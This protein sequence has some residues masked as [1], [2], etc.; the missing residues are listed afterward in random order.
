MRGSQF[1]SDRP[2]AW[3]PLLLLALT[4]AAPLLTG[5]VVSAPAE[6]P[7]PP[8]KLR[9]GDAAAPIRY[10][11]DLTVVP[12]ND[13]FAGTIEIDLQLRQPTS[14]LWVNGSDLTVREA[15][16][17]VRGQSLPARPVPG[18]E[19]FLGFAFDRPVGPGPALLK[20]AYQGKMSEREQAGLFRRKDGEHWYVF[21][22]FEPL[23]ARRA[24][25][26]FDE[27]AYKVPWQLTLHVKRE[28]IALSNT[29]ILAETDEPE[30][31]KAVRFA[32]T[33]PLPSYLVALTVGPF[34]VVDAGRVG[35]KRTPIRIITPRGRAGEAGYAA[36]TTGEILTRL[37]NYFGRPY[38]YEKLDQVAIPQVGFAMENAGLVTYSQTGIL[39]RPQDQTLRFQRGFAGVCAHELAHQWF[40]DLVT[41][42]WWDDLWLNEAFATWMDPKIVDQWKPEW[43]EK[44]SSVRR[45]HWAMESDS[46]VTARRIRQPIESR[47]DIQNA[48]DGIT[49]SKGAAVLDMFETWVGE[50]TFRNGVRR[51]MARHAWGNATAEDFIRA[52]SE[53]AGRDLMPA[54]STFL[55]Q[56]GV[57]LVT[58]ELKCDNGARP[59]LVLA[60]ERYLP[61]G[62][63]GSARQTWQI[64]LRIRYGGPTEGREQTLLTEATVELPLGAAT[65]CPRWVLANEDQAGYYRVLYQGDLLS[66]LLTERGARLTLAERAGLVSDLGAFVRSGRMAAGEVLARVPD[67]L[68]ESDRHIVSG[69]VDIVLGM[70]NLI[71]DELR[72]HYARYI[73]KIYGPR[74]RALGWRPRKGEDDETR[75]LRPQLLGLV[76]GEG[77]DPVLIAEA[78]RLARRWLDDRRSL[79]GDLVGPILRIAARNGDRAL[80]DR[81]HAEARKTTDLRQRNDLLWAMSAFR[82]AEILKAAFAIP[83]TDE[84]HPTEAMGLIWGPSGDPKTRP[85]AYEFVKTNFDAL[86]AKL[87]RDEGAYLPYIAGGFC[88]EERRAEV[89]AFFKDRSTKF[90]GGP[91]VLAQVLEGIRLCTALKTAQQPSLEA[92]LMKF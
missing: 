12:T 44:L 35:K 45:N 37:E 63:Q 74:A 40:G 32:E 87:P 56:P 66:R 8:P 91:R 31:M 5:P 47:H 70:N 79:D 9:L 14:L 42:A 59:R 28:Q 39:A 57:P 78:G 11:L 49:Y 86:V 76:A 19:D 65:E 53:A 83:L 82:D 89:E 36:R 7:P 18:G 62:S 34:D 88:D 43:K 17:Q 21:T 60:Q 51:Y 90:T 77:E 64:P 81:L 55:D 25:P 6:A 41:M 52:L 80:F 26:C 2:A 29:P 92:F 50:V 15:H 16:L 73:R 72:P 61:A 30:G 23:D 71:P 24:F 85:L 27:P 13:T 4:W 68:R 10:T 1:S 84:F 20:V 54:F 75:L 48:F 22:Q 33:R 46:L 58:V 38:P 67:L 69:T 3:I